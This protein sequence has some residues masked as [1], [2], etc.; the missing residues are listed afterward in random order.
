MFEKQRVQLISKSNTMK[1]LVFISGLILVFLTTTAFTTFNFEKPSFSGDKGTKVSLWIPGFAFKMGSWF[2]PKHEEPELKYLLK[3]IKSLKVKVR[4]GEHY[5]TAMTKE[6]HRLN[7][8][9]IKQNFEELITVNDEEAKV[10]VKL[11]EKA[12]GNISD[13][14]VLV[15]D[16][17][18]A[19]VYVKMKC[20]LSMKDI[21]KLLKESE[22]FENPMKSLKENI[23]D[24]D[25]D[26]QK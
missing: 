8:K 20:N 23:D 18:E 10:V 11:K 15:D 3:K 9:L 6:F 25:I 5:K 7:N 12:N 1:R 13:F 21:S 19:F 14:V 16:R 22:L 24:L 4:E 17:E 26:V 2:V